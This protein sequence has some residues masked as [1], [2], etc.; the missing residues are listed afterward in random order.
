MCGCTTLLNFFQVVLSVKEFKN[1][2]NKIIDMMKDK[3]AEA[4]GYYGDSDLGEDELDIS[5][6]DE[7]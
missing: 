3:A 2:I 1:Y 7:V 5:F 6:I 4:D